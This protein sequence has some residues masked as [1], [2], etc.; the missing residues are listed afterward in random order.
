MNTEIASNF[1]GKNYSEE[2]VKDII[3]NK[4]ISEKKNIF[5]QIKSDEFYNVYITEL[6]E[7]RNQIYDD[8][9]SFDNKIDDIS[10]LL[11]NKVIE[12]ANYFKNRNVPF[13]D[14]LSNPSLARLVITDLFSYYDNGMKFFNNSFEIS[15]KVDS[16]PDEFENADQAIEFYNDSIT[17]INDLTKYQKI[18][19]K[20]WNY[21]IE[22]YIFSSIVNE[23]YEYEDKI[24][25]KK[26]LDIYLKD[27]QTLGLDQQAFEIKSY[28]DKVLKLDSN[29]K[30][31][32]KEKSTENSAEKKLFD[33]YQ[34]K[35][36]ET[37]N[38]MTNL[39]L[40]DKKLINA[41]I[42]LNNKVVELVHV[43]RRKGKDFYDFSVLVKTS[44]TVLDEYYKR[45]YIALKHYDIDDY[46][47]N[48][49]KIYNFSIEKYIAPYFTEEV[50]EDWNETYKYRFSSCKRELE[51]MG[52][53]EKNNEKNIVRDEER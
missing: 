24:E 10:V 9:K 38:L 4:L 12:V 30:E 52:Y 41:G 25:F 6:W 19:K 37:R 21:N 28:F 35:I 26:R 53:L 42:I 17:F 3:F 31:D 40:K 48:C 7:N 34:R 50:K 11:N 45:A 22:K 23:Y 29:N 33:S 18:S 27:I 15:Q 44:L 51:G 5:N 36:A 2:K 20:L 13:Y 49:N 8:A 32:K 14:N 39:N 16:M 43:F 47:D 1:D 46:K